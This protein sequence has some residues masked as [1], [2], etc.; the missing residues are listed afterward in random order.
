MF[1]LLLRCS[2]IALALWS[3]GCQKKVSGD[4]SGSPPTAVDLVARGRSVYQANCIACHNN[5]PRLAGALGPEIAKSPLELVQ[6]RVMKAEY[7]KDYKPKRST[8]VMQPLPQLKDD[9]PA[10]HAY[11]DSL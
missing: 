5:D 1:L 11:L 10:L 7:P 2:A 9:I 8:H 3:I 4:S 6:S